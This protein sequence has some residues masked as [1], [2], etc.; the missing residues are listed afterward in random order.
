MDK[1]DTPVEATERLQAEFPAEDFADPEDRAEILR[2]TE[3]IAPEQTAVALDH[4]LRGL[5]GTGEVDCEALAKEIGTD[6]ERAY[7]MVLRMVDA[8]S[9]LVTANLFHGDQDL[10]REFVQWALK[11]ERAL[12]VRA[13]EVSARTQSSRPMAALVQRRIAALKAPAKQKTRPQQ[14]RAS[15]AQQRDRSHDENTVAGVLRRA[16]EENRRLERAFS[17]RPY[18]WE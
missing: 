15:G 8:H 17:N 13:A 9:R 10:H 2:V 3:G 16:D 5:A 4:V 1:D 11:N 6:P 12:Y 14:S 18:E 7:E